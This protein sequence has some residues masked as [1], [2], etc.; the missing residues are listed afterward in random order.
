MKKLSFIQKS[1]FGI[2]LV[3]LCASCVDTEELQPDLSTEELTLLTENSTTGEENLRKGKATD[4]AYF[5]RFR[6]QIVPS[7]F[8]EGLFFPGTGVGNSTHMGKALT[9]LNQKL[10]VSP[11]GFPTTIGA[12]VTDFHAAA[13]D[14][15]GLN[16]SIIPAK[17]SSITTDGKG[18]SVWFENVLNIV[19]EPDENNIQT[20]EAQVVIVGGTGKF[21]GATGSGTVIGFFNSITGVG[22]STIKGR[23]TY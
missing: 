2:S 8:A 7:Q 4:R 10:V 21:E 6:N 20:F 11:E 9:F 19:Q 22:S 14:E 5:E 3:F 12:P 23:I 13:L 1:L 18:N 16:T 15:L 17:V